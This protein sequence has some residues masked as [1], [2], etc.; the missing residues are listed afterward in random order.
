MPPVVIGQTRFEVIHWGKEH[1]RVEKLV[2][3]APEP[4]VAETLRVCMA[5]NGREYNCGS[6]DKC[7]G[8]ML[9][10]EALGMLEGTLLARLGERNGADELSAVCYQ[11]AKPCCCPVNCG[12]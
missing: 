9:V 10:L 6:C 7:V 4:M 12:E 8:A 11:Q 3:I 2:A 1:S 5:S